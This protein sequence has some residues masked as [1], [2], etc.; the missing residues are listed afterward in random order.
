MN[1]IFAGIVIICV[2]LFS[3]CVST[4]APV[5]P[6]E[7]LVDVSPITIKEFQNADMVISIANNG[8]KP[9]DSVKVE[10]INP[11]IV[12]QASGSPNI[13]ARTKDG[14]SQINMNLKVEAPGF[15]AD[16]ANTMLL[17]SYKSGKNDKGEPIIKTKSVAVKATVLPNAKLQFVG[18]VKGL[19]N[20]SEA[21]LTSWEL[22][23][24]KNATITFSVK[25]EGRTTIDKN[26][27]NVIV[28]IQNKEIGS[29][30][31]LTIKEG[32]AK[33]GTSYT[34]AVVLPINKDAPNGLTDVLVTLYMG[35][36]II[37]TKTLQLKV[38]L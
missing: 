29:S 38:A 20:K 26:T 10:S 3:G 21:E 15:K 31:N 1:R 34:E 27:L 14:V 37:D 4:I 11:F 22:K 16:V 17:L 6:D 19:E 33:E 23:K 28:D 13:P 7:V 35:E 32:M 36:N 18:F 5:N 8:S 30:T 9:I 24:G 2:I 12:V 25:N